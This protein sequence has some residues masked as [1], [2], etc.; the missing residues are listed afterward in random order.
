MHVVWDD[1]EAAMDAIEDAAA[2]PDPSL[3]ALSNRLG[4]D[5]LETAV[6][7]ITGYRDRGEYARFPAG[8]RH[9]ERL[10]AMARLDESRIDLTTCTLDDAVRRL[11]STGEVTN[12]RVS[13]D[14]VSEIMQLDDGHWKL[15]RR[16]GSTAVGGECSG[17]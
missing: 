7:V 14:R 4:G 11:R 12:D 8:S 1:Y 17:M 9:G 16:T 2:V 3:P 6:R 10:I 5:A 13:V 15:V